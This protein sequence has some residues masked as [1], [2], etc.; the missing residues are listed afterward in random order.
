[1]EAGAARYLAAV[2]ARWLDEEPQTRWRE[3]DATLLFADV[4]GFTALGERLARSGR[5]GT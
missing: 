5:V 2:H 4:S 1:M 3:L